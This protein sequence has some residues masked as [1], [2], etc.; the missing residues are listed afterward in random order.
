MRGLTDD[1]ASDYREVKLVMSFGLREIEVLEP[2]V[3]NCFVLLRPRISRSGSKVGHALKHDLE[4]Y[5]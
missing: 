1:C 5:V 3:Q 4:L 2:A